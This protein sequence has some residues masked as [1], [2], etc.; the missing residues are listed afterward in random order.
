MEVEVGALVGYQAGKPPRVRNHG[1]AEQLPQ[2]SCPRPQQPVGAVRLR[3]PVVLGDPAEVILERI[4][5]NGNVVVPET[6]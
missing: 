5:Q 2:E 1:L 4:P 3:C 6:A